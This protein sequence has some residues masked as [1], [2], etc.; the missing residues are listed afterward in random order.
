MA[1]KN[2]DES[3]YPKSLGKSM[4]SPSV[5]VAAGRKR[6]RTKRAAEGDVVLFPVADDDTPIVTVTHGAKIVSLLEE[7]RDGINN[8]NETLLERLR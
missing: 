4:G 6:T 1:G 8:V 2:I 7:I 5:V 3:G